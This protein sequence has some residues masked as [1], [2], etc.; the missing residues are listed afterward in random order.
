[1]RSAAFRF[2]L[3]S[4]TVTVYS[5]FLQFYYCRMLPVSSPASFSGCVLTPLDCPVLPARR[6]RPLR[7]TGQRQAAQRA[8]G[9]QRPFGRKRAAGPR[10]AARGTGTE[11]GCRPCFRPAA[12]A[13]RKD[14]RS[15]VSKCLAHNE[16]SLKT[17]LGV[18]LLTG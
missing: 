3:N 11:D 2:L 13:R 4:S 14:R 12:K 15:D 6:L 17:A 5:N 16:H 1:M 7:L 8:Q 18:E 10:S 9:A